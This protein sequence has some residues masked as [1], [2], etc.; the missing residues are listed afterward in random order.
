MSWHS[1][2]DRLQVGPHTVE[3]RPK[4]SWYFSRGLKHHIGV[5]LY[6]LTVVAQAVRD[7]SS[8]VVVDSGTTHWIV[9]SLLSVL[10]IPVIAVQHST[11]WPAGFPP[12]RLIDRFMLPLD[13]FFFRHIAAATVCASPECERQVRKMARTPKGP[14]Y[15]FLP[16]YHR[17]FMSRVNPVPD[18]GVRPFRVL[19]LGRVEDYKGVFQILSIAERLEEEMPGQF[20][21]KIVGAGSAF[22]TL[23]HQVILRRLSHLVEVSGMLPDETK[24]QETLGWCHAMIVPTTSQFQEGLAMTAVEAIL[25]GR[26]VV[27]SDVVPAWEILGSAAIK[28]E[29]DNIDSFVANFRKLALDPE[30]YNECQRA[31]CGL[32]ARFY[33]RSNGPGA[34]LGRAI[35]ALL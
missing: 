7:R 10:R 3:N 29:T 35:S 32:Q 16:Q 25:A 8:L 20:V 4:P 22:E 12:T 33:E 26:P 2:K 1:R 13:G 24:A 15:R 27:V 28:A 31:T 17:D 5:I 6:G 18:Y 34:V 30:Y 21:W 9:L 11:F 19:F 14:I 23:G